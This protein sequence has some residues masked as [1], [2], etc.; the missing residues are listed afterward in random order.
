M[1]GFV[2]KDI[3][4]KISILR[5]H[6][7]SSK[8][9]HYMTIQDMIHYEV[10]LDRTRAPQQHLPA[11]GSRTLLRLHRAL[12]F[13]LE[14][15]RGIITSS[16]NTSSAHIASNTYNHTLAQYHPWSVYYHSQTI[17]IYNTKLLTGFPVSMEFCMFLIRIS[18][19]L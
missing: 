5:N 4:S 9:D 15:M 17:V 18:L 19:L 14:F 3:E 10:R 16:D 13:I 2:A 12:E 1:F 6:Q 8:G 7:S 11:N